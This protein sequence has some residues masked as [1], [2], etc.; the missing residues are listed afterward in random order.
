MSNKNYGKKRT[1]PYRRKREGKTNYK[2]RLAL[3]KSGKPVLVLR[4]LSNTIVCQIVEF[5]PDGDRIVAA[6]SSRDLKKIG[7]AGHPSNTPSA[8]LTGLLLGQKAKKKKVSFAILDI[9]FHTS[10]KGSRVYAAL[11]GAL[12][13][14]LDVP[15]SDDAL[16]S[17]ERIS[18]K[19]ISAYADKLKQ[20][21]EA[22][23][24]Q[25]SG[26][27]KQGAK[28]EELSSKFEEVKKKILTM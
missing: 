12:D 9:G 17:A 14:G 20:D 3:L 1:V 19:H 7:W 28:P 24:R 6:A 5:N 26:Y 18:G 11:K 10:R 13:A 2:S 15:H 4:M 16:P 23:K 25:F 21:Q 27:L 22:Y 8:Y